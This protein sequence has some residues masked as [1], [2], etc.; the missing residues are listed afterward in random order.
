VYPFSPLNK[1]LSQ[2]Y[3]YMSTEAYF[4]TFD[5]NIAPFLTENGYVSNIIFDINQ[6]DHMRM[7]GV[8]YIGALDES[9]LPP[10]LSFTYAYSLDDL[11]V[12]QIDNYL[13][14]GHT[15]SRFVS[16]LADV[17]DYCE[18]LYVPAAVQAEL[19]GITPHAKNQFTVT[20][21]S[22]RGLTGT[23]TVPQK[24]VLFMGFPNSSGWQ[25]YDRDNVKLETFDVQGGFLG[26]V[27]EPGEHVL[28]F[29]FTPPGIRAGALLSGIVLAA[30]L[31]GLYRENRRK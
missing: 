29:T 5:N 6:P 12:Y 17:S 23:I 20:A 30:V 13:H 16:E 3:N 15:Y 1:N 19:R 2:Q 9:E 31:Y 4:S 22:H 28:T 8:K 10:E 27:L 21:F 11:K 25:V 7:L 14:I 18:E 24:C 26:L